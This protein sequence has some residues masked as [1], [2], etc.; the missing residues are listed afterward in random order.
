[1]SF[2]LFERSISV[3]IFIM[4]IVCLRALLI[5]RMPKKMFLMLWGIAMVR[6][7]VPHSFLFRWNILTILNQIFSRVTQEPVS[8]SNAINRLFL[9]TEENLGPLTRDISFVQNSFSLDTTTIIWLAGAISLGI[10]FALTFYTNNKVLKTAL[11]VRNQPVIDKWLSEQ[12]TIRRIQVMTFD[13]IVSPIACGLVKPRILLPKSL[14]LH[15]EK[16]LKH[17][18]THEKMHIKH[19]DIIWK[20]L[21]ALILCCY[22][23]NPFVWLMHIL[24]NRDLELTCDE[25]VLRTLGEEER[26][27]YA[28]SLI[29]MAER[30]A[31]L[32]SLHYGFS[33]NST[34]GRIVSIMKYKQTTALT[35][36]LSTA[37]IVGAVTVFATNVNQAGVSPMTEKAKASREITEGLVTSIDGIKSNISD[38]DSAV[39]IKDVSESADDY[40]L[41]SYSYEEYKAQMGDVKRV[42][43]DLVNR[44]SMSRDK[45][46]QVLSSMQDT[47]GEIKR[48]EIVVYKPIEI[49]DS[50]NA[51]AKDKETSSLYLSGTKW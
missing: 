17:I 44:G 22:W 37:L 31:R 25:R 23:F 49:P 4:V 30:N 10:F 34:K 42:G 39:Y 26:S 45:L 32:G 38:R 13:R 21:S 33:N 14:D 28:L 12:K 40:G 1:M 36:C 27:G 46:S 11:P 7:V 16:L 20:F 47:L 8:Q 51:R 9:A 15:N 43:E 3:G 48:D 6:L 35:L 24:I 41:E 2:F 29:H 5:N 18:L 50:T 19:L